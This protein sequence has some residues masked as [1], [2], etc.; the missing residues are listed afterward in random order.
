LFN[1]IKGI[2][3]AVMMKYRIGISM[4][5]KNWQVAIVARQRNG[6]RLLETMSTEKSVENLKEIFRQVRRRKRFGVC[7][8]L[9]LPYHQTW[10]KEIQLDTGLTDSEIYRYLQQQAPI[11]FGKPTAHWFFDFTPGLRDKT[12]IVAAAREHVTEWLALARACQLPVH[13]VDVDVL[14]LARLLRTLD[15]YHPNQP[16]AL[17]WPNTTDLIF[18]VAQAGQL[19]YAKKALYSPTQ[20]LS[21]VLTSLSQFFTRLYPEYPLTDFLLLSDQDASVPHLPIKIARL[22]PALWQTSETVTAHQ[23]CALGLAIYGD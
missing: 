18:M 4:T 1:K 15:A 2:Y 3:T 13:A 7:A 8:V 17:I 23:F 14:A 16:Q 5:E 22:N 6:W 9:G 20:P 21:D 11:L 19:I 12:R 10:M